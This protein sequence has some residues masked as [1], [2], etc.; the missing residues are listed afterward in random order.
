MSEKEARDSR[1]RRSTLAVELQDKGKRLS[2]VRR[3]SAFDLVAKG[4]DEITREQFEKLHDV[5]A[6]EMEAEMEA[7]ATLAKKTAAIKRKLKLFICALASLMFVLT[8]SL[9]GNFFIVFFVVDGQV[10]TTTTHNGLLEAKNSDMIVKTATATEDLPL[11]VAPIL[12]L[13][14]LSSAKSLKVSYNDGLNMVEAELGLA[15]VRKHNS[16]FVEFTT[17]VPGETVEVLNGLAHLVRVHPA[18]VHKPSF[19][20]KHPICSANATCSA[21]T[22][23]G[24]DTDDA[25]DRAATELAKHGFVN[26]ADGSG[27]CVD[28]PD[29]LVAVNSHN[30]VSSCAEAGERGL[31]DEPAVKQ[32][33]CLT[34]TG[35]DQPHHGRSMSSKGWCAP[36]FE[37]VTSEWSGGGTQE[38]ASA[39]LRYYT[40][41]FGTRNVVYFLHGFSSH[42]TFMRDYVGTS[43]DSFDYRKFLFVFPTSGELAWGQRSW[44][45]N[46]GWWPSS[47]AYDY[48]GVA[49]PQL[50]NFAADINGQ[51][52]VSSSSKYFAIGLSDGGRAAITANL[53]NSR[54]RSGSS[55]H[56]AVGIGGHPMGDYDTNPSPSGIP[57]VMST[58]GVRVH[59]WFTDSDFFYEGNAMEAYANAV[60]SS[61]SSSRTSPTVAGYTFTRDEWSSSSGKCQRRVV[62]EVHSGTQFGATGTEPAPT[63]HVEFCSGNGA[64]FD[65]I[66]A[67]SLAQFTADMAPC[68][69][70]SI[71][72][73]SG[74]AP[75]VVMDQWVQ[76]HINAQE[77]EAETP[78]ATISDSDSGK[79]RSFYNVPA[80]SAR[81]MWM[82]RLLE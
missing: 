10:K 42:G 25:L 8:L 20:T 78:D 19:R 57:G 63:S 80:E 73:M 69:S 12:D 52:G 32:G 76:D 50:D 14:T 70:R 31:C 2:E 54:R 68:P 26:A 65:A 72:K 47:N 59:S 51:Y 71:G 5:I 56:S 11:I 44:K 82:D 48:L 1:M 13:D 74:P 22:V 55:I 9:L 30:T 37:W 75:V 17:T 77:A 16:T 3:A 49:V 66:V 21:F 64:L 40:G 39:H 35:R 33:C 7:A 38:F 61:W 60:S 62:F 23:G 6:A 67:D 34:C 46:S 45:S 53:F 24:V 15:G 81:D 43:L 4:G 79:S 41:W 27:K 36:S 28:A 18:S 29:L 58:I